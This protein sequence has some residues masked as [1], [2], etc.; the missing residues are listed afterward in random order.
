M[1]EYS[2]CSSVHLN[3]R[4]ACIFGRDVFVNCS[5]A[6]LHWVIDTT[7]PPIGQIKGNGSLSSS[8]SI[9]H[10]VALSTKV[11]LRLPR[12][13]HT[14]KSPASPITSTPISDFFLL[15]SFS[16]YHQQSTQLNH[17]LPQSAFFASRIKLLHQKSSKTTKFNQ[18]DW[19]KIRRQGQ[20]FQERAIVSCS[21]FST[22]AMKNFYSSRPFSRSSKAGLAFPVGRVHRLLRKGN[23][24][25]RVGAGMS[26]SIQSTSHNSSL[27]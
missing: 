26:R 7:R 23:Y 12:A 20:R 25:Q 14:L 10:S 2:I 9:S 22:N 8:S 5:A 19:R 11:D 16:I 4:C 27:T 17:P 24:A 21:L 6:S 1:G 18:N 13:L 3:R 15:P